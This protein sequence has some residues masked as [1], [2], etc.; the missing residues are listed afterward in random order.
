[1]AELLRIGEVADAV[2]VSV[3][4]LRRWEAAGRVEFVR[5]GGQRFL[6]AEALGPLIRSQATISAGNRLAGT[7]V[8]VERDGVMAKVEM[9]C[10]P[11]RV[12]SLM[13]AEA[14]TDLGLEPGV[15]AAALVEAVSVMIER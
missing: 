3:E 10:G 5:R 12:V 15:E 13:S 4:T 7:V 1:M 14:A 8:A 11:Y 6:A 9:A 2:G